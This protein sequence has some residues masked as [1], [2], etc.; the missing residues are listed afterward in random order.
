MLTFLSSIGKQNQIKLRTARRFI[1]YG[2]DFIIIT[3]VVLILYL[4]CMQ[5]YDPFWVIV[6]FLRDISYKVPS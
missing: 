3:L 2:G 5:L 6:M 1:G 4:F